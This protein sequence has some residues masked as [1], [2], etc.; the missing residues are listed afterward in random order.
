MSMIFLSCH[1]LTFMLRMHV[2]G[3]KVAVMFLYDLVVFWALTFGPSLASMHRACWHH[4]NSANF[5]CGES[6]LTAFIATVLVIFWAVLPYYVLGTSLATLFW[7]LLIWACLL[8]VGK[9]PK[10]FEFSFSIEALQ[11]RP[12]C[13]FRTF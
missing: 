7:L 6:C 13:C 1:T 12:H 9:L 4:R 8:C 10:H 5:H 3:H 11:S 2:L